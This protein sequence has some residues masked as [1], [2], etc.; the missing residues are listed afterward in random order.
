MAHVHLTLQ[1]L[2]ELVTLQAQRGKSRNEIVA[3]L[4]ARGWPRESAEHFVDTTL[5]EHHE[6]TASRPTQPDDQ[7]PAG[8]SPTD[9]QAM[10]RTLLIVVILTLLILVMCGLISNGG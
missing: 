7:T 10:W 8:R 4:I 6:R 3:V 1:E 9:E 2:S 5:S